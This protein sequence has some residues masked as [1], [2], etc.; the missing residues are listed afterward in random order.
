VPG[1]AK[2]DS[3][4]RAF[5]STVP[6]LE[7][8]RRVTPSTDHAA[9][10]ALIAEWSAAA[11]PGPPPGAP[12]SELRV[13]CLGTAVAGALSGTALAELGADVVKIEAP[14]RPDNMRRLSQPRH[15]VA[16]EPSG[17][18]T[19]PMFG[20]NN[21][22][23]RSVALD[24]KEP[25]AVDLFLR[26]VAACDVIIENYSPSVMPKWGLTYERIARANPRVIMLSLTG[27][28]HTGPR[29]S[30]LAYGS[31]VSSFV[32]VTQAW[33]YPSST[34]FD[35]ISQAH[36][37]FA[38][39]AALAARDRSGN[40]THI[41]LAEVEVGAAVVGPLMLDYIVNGRDSEPLGN[42]VPGALY[43]AVLPCHGDDAWLAVELEDAEDARRLY[44]LLGA[45]D[46]TPCQSG[47]H[48]EVEDSLRGW[49]SS[50]T[51]YQA[52][53]GLQRAGL[54]A[55]AVQ[56]NE[57]VTRDP[58]HRARGFLIDMH[59]PDMGTIEYAAPPHRLSKTPA[60]AGRHTPRLGEHNFE[61]LRGW[62][63]LS[64]EQASA[65]S[66]PRPESAAAPEAD[67]EA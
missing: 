35:Y 39:L 62:A 48:P 38:V 33:G 52:M 10:A 34:F 42:N 60:R 36:G 16:T 11:E 55:G 37:V 56:S 22:T 1:V 2:F 28:G 27:F 13:L 40:G 15:M 21:R 53:R 7:P 61:V 51:A 41:D 19:S 5:A 65:W 14:G 29:A 49:A 63:G 67:T 45:G 3:P 54:A 26:L 9:A 20:S 66:W 12:L 47:L 8:Y 25:G 17:A 24:M 6:L 58:Q 57:D 59:H 30:Y 46:R 31:T 44:A 23:I 18:K 43:S 50:R 4:G 32:G 64:A